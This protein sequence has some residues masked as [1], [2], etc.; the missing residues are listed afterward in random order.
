MIPKWRF[1]EFPSWIPDKPQMAGVVLGHGF[2][3]FCGCLKP[4]MIAMKSNHLP[5]IMAGYFLATLTV[6]KWQNCHFEK[7]EPW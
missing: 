2:A 6:R 5:R 7:H 1:T 3:G 4:S